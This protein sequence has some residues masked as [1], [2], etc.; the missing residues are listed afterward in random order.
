MSHIVDQ[1]YLYT[2]ICLGPRYFSK[3]RRGLDRM[4]VDFT[5]TYAIMTYHQ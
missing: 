1:H 5:N 3:G 4:V 2:C